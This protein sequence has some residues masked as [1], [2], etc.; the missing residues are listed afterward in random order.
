MKIRDRI[1]VLR[2]TLNRKPSLDAEEV[3]YA[4]KL[5]AELMA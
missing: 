3:H 5:L 1:E 2:D 4:H